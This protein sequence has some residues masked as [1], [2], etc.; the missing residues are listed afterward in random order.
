MPLTFQVASATTL[1]V[2]N[3]GQGHAWRLARNVLMWVGMKH[4]KAQLEN[5]RMQGQH[6]KWD[7][8]SSASQLSSKSSIDLEKK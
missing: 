1:L 7:T 5:V 4:L 3:K 2:L 8:S 6:V